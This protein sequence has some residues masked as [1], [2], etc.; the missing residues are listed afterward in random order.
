MSKISERLGYIH[1]MMDGLKLD[2]D[3]DRIKLCGMIVDV[4]DDMSQAIDKL[5][6]DHQDLSDYVES[7]DDDLTDLEMEHGE[8]DF[9]DDED[10]FDFEEVISPRK[11]AGLH[12]LRDADELNDED[13]DEDFDE[14]EYEEAETEFYIGCVCP[15][16]GKFFSVKNP[17]DYDDDQ[18]FECPFCKKHVVIAPMDP[19]SV[20]CAKPVSD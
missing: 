12:I 19:S 15:E 18:K 20:P 6:S 9:M 8:G 4:L 7:I 14:D 13:D 3:D 11:K 1:G 5:E 17:D 2:K 10:D 16:C